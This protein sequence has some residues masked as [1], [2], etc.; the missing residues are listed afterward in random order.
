MKAY[1][2]NPDDRT[3]TE[4]EWHRRTVNQ[5]DKIYA[6][7]NC[8][9]ITAVHPWPGRDAIYV[10]DEGLMGGPVYQFFGVLGYPQPVAGRG[11]VVGTGSDGEDQTPTITMPDLIS[12]TVF[13][14]RLTNKLWGIY[15]ATNPRNGE[16]VTLDQI[17]ERLQNK[18]GQGSP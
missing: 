3:I 16:T 14:E 4:H 5:L 13:I 7:V 1:L 6:L 8:Q 10:D 9:T 15:P 11:L 12:Q 17:I 2:I 18:S